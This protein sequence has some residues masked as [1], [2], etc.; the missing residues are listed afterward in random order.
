MTS[1]T[2]PNSDQAWMERALVLARES[3]GHVWPNPPVGC[4]VVKD[5]EAVA[6]AAP[7]VN[8]GGFEGLRRAGSD[9]TIGGG[10]EPAKTLT[11]GFFHRIRTG[12]PEVMASTV[13]P[14][15]IPDGVDGVLVSRKKAVFLTTRS[16]TIESELRNPHHLLEWMG[17][18]GLTTV[19][20]PKQ[21]AF[22]CHGQS[23]GDVNECNYTSKTIS[24][25]REIGA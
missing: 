5:G 13:G 2:L 19:A 17:D 3:R 9:V 20:I 22:L 12:T 14:G 24:P 21:D 1:R 10:A 11:S 15:L 23:H 4:V 6:E 16:G 7:R 18:L 8:G 25:L